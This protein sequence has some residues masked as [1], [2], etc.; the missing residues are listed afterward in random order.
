MGVYGFF[1]DAGALNPVVG[2][3]VYQMPS[4]GSSVPADQLVYYGA[5]L[6]SPR[7]VAKQKDAP[8]V[9]Q[10]QVSVAD[11][12]PGSGHET[13]AVTFSDTSDF[14]GKIAGDPMDLGVEILD[15]PGGLVPIYVRFRDAT[16]TQ[17]NSVE[18]SIQ[19][20]DVAEYDQ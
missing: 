11:S 3:L 7:V 20:L 15:G 4:D 18:I 2:P 1:H 6:Q 17:G 10:L 9:N 5:A 19:V 13:T 12:S 14:T 16:M 8:G